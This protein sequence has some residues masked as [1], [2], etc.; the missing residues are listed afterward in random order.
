M[1]GPVMD[2][3]ARGEL[4][5]SVSQ[6]GQ[7]GVDGAEVALA[8]RN[9]GSAGGSGHVLIYC[10]QGAN[11]SP[12]WALLCICVVTDSPVE[13]VYEMLRKVR[14]IVYVE[15]HYRWPP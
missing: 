7:G 3:G 11:R 5:E 6:V 1:S 10:R 9:L 4:G 14:P 2:Q 8:H 13:P 15:P 12:C